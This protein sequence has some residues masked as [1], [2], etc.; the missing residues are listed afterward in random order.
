MKLLGYEFKMILPFG[1]GEHKTIYELT[2]LKSSWFGFIKKEVKM[3]YEISM[4]G[5]ISDYEKH[6][7]GLI[8]SGAKL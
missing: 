8:E 2:V 3:N 1:D 7:D 5:N 6:W 4:F